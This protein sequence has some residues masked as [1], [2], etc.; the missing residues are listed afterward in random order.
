MVGTAGRRRNQI[1]PPRAAFAHPT[2]CAILHDVIRT[3]TGL[4]ADTFQIGRVFT[5]LPWAMWLIE[6]T[7]AFRAW[8]AGATVLDPT[9]GD[10]VFLEA[11]VA[12]A[13]RDG[14]S[15]PRDAL[16]RLH[17][18]E[19]VAADRA[20]ALERIRTRYG[21]KLA[22]RN[23]RTADFITATFPGRYDILAGNPPWI[24][25]TDLPAGLKAKWGP[26]YIRHQLVTDK[27][28]VLLGGSRADLA[29]LVLKKALDDVLSNAG[30]A[31]FFIPL[32]IF[33]NSG[34]NDRFRPFPSSAHTYRVV[35]LWDFGQEAVFDGVS[36]RYGAALF[37]RRGPQAWPV[38]T[39]VRSNGNWTQAYSTASDHR[40]GTWHQH[41]TP[42]ADRGAPPAIGISPSQKP[43]QGANT[44]G[45]NDVF[46]FERDGGRLRNG[47]GE[48]WELEEELLFPLMNASNFGR[49]LDGGGRSAGVPPALVTPACETERAGRPRSGRALLQRWILLPHDTRTGRP[50][51]WDAIAKHERAAAYLAKH[52]DLLMRR[53]GTLINSQIGRGF[54]WALLGVGPYAF[55]PWKVAWEALGK[56]SFT[57]AVLDG[58]WQGNQALH[59]FCPCDT[60]QD[61]DAL[62]AA[63]RRT[64][65]ETWLKS[66]AMAGTCNWAQ[67]GRIAQVLTMREQRR[68]VG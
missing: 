20:R 64:E 13:R 16:A 8:L 41:R 59:A 10:G 11:F 40:G 36:T 31:A 47:L 58:R 3:R 33:F 15:I 14:V 49:L 53:K 19:I 9:C 66:S 54:W 45:A 67:P 17:G 46:I 23:I 18:V 56:K 39:H 22:G 50:L 62:A 60:R 32:S 37:D 55:A 52:R 2:R 44:C 29:A 7:G 65:V 27:R 30:Q 43:R 48:E 4:M 25:F 28:D 68:I 12:L 6:T 26:E 21:A 38:E 35:R 1:K 57:P 34:A 42:D 51:A 24:N 63:L 5:P 61:A